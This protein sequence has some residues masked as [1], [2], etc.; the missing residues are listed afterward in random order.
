MRIIK[1]VRIWGCEKVNVDGS[2]NA[3]PYD[4]SNKYVLGNVKNNTF[5]EII[6]SEKSKRFRKAVI[7]GDHEFLDAIGY[8][9]AKCNTWTDKVGY[10]ISRYLQ[11][12]Y[13]TLLGLVVDE[14]GTIK[15]YYDCTYLNQI[16]ESLD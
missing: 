6:N 7:E 12:T 15:D 1:Y 9:C 11:E 10:N 3:C 4:F 16:L 14:I 2:V 8:H 13:P 5:D